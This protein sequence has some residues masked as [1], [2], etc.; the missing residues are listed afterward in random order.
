[1]GV[2]QEDSI[3]EIYATRAKE[4]CDYFEYQAQKL[5]DLQNMQEA[6][7]N[8]KREKLLNKLRELDANKELPITYGKLSQY[9]RGLKAKD[10][11]ELLNGYIKEKDKRIFMILK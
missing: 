9:F 2:T 7:N 1:M 10:C 6:K 4:L 3:S 11:Q 8:N 5:Y